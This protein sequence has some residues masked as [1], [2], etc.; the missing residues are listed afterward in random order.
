MKKLIT[1]A[2]PTASGKTGLALLL[3]GQLGGEIIGADSMQIY[4]QIQ[5]GTAR[6]TRQETGEI[7]YHMIDCVPPDAFYTVSQFKDDALRVIGQITARGKTP[8]VCGGTGLYVNA[9]LYEM[10]FSDGDFDVAYRQRLQSQTLDELTARLQEVDAATYRTIDRKNR[11][12]VERALEIYHLTGKEKSRQT[13]DYMQHPRPFDHRVFLIDMPRELLYERIDARVDSMLQSGLVEEVR[14]LRRQGFAEDLPVFQFI[15]YQQILSHLK[16]ELSLEQATL[17]I[18][19]NTRHFAKRQLTW[20]KKLTGVPIHW[21]AHS[22]DTQQML[23]QMMEKLD[24][25]NE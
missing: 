12:R 10:D 15:G 7:A 17:D 21:V 4:Q 23:T 13:G 22:E 25:P 20:F 1:I 8:I 6:P 5:I 16:G 11:R 18:K 2:G 19:K 14:Q 9:L 3:A 24:E